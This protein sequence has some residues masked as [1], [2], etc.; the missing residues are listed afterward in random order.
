MGHGLWE[1]SFQPLTFLVEQ[2]AVPAQSVRPGHTRSVGRPASRP[3]RLLV[4]ISVTCPAREAQSATEDL[5][6]QAVTRVSGSQ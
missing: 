5:T 3:S 4:P 2:L 1:V 6:F